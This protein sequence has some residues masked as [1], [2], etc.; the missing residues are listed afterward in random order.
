M[1][2]AEDLKDRV[3]RRKTE[4]FWVDLEKKDNDGEV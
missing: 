3:L 2:T 1:G 4:K